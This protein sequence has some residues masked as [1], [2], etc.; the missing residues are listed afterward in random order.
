MPFSAEAELAVLSSMLF[1]REAVIIAHELLIGDDFYRPDY[2]AIFEAMVELFSSGSPVDAVTLKNILEKKGLFD[3]VGGG[4]ALAEMASNVSSTANMKHYAGIMRD[5]TL[6]RRLIKASGDITAK[7][8][9]GA[10]EADD[11]LEFAEKSIFD[12]AQNR[13]STD[14]VHIKDAL[15]ESI[16]KI[17]DIYKHGQKITGIATGFTDFDAKTAGLHPANLILIASRPSMGKS[18]L[19]LNIAQNAAIRQK[20]PTAFFALEMS[21]MECTNRIICSEASVQAQKMRTGELDGS[22]WNNIAMAI[23]PI[24]EAP[25]Y[26]D[27]TPGIT[28]PEL[29]AKCR[30]LK[31]EKGLGLIVIDYLQLMNGS[32]KSESRQQEISEISRSLKSI[33]REMDAPVIALAQLSRACEQRADHRPI[34]SDLRESGAIEQDADVVGFIYRDEYYNKDSEKRGIAEIIIAKQRNGPTG[35][36]ELAFLG[37]YVRFNNLTHY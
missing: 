11:V 21:R 16:L 35:T 13:T 31:L 23:G 19:G 3:R 27:D 22:D 8:L 18:V 30:R 14:F 15:T 10:G 32:R 36:V 2:R 1:D 25:L 6:L 37:D 5:R 7:S 34:L 24:S 12:I 28:I 17:E 20:V 29:R 4:G 9:E 26:L 33:A